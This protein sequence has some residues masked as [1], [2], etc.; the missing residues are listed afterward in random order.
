M[1]TFTISGFSDEINEKID[2]Q[3]AHIKSLGIEYFEPRGV[4]GTNIADL[5]DEQVAYLK[6]RMDK[7]GIKVSSIGSP[8][9]KIKITDNFE[10]HIAK[11]ELVEY[12][13]YVGNYY[14]TPRAYVEE[15]LSK[16]MNVILDI[17]VQGA[18]Q[19]NEKMP[20]AV[21]IFIIP[22][23]L[24]ELKRRLE[25]RGTDTARAIEARL[26]RA[27]QEY[28]EADFYDYIIINDDAD[29]AAQEFNAIITAEGCRASRRSFYLEK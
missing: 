9:G 27:R 24:D 22:P 1:K 25:G 26:I 18:R 19:V 10:E 28:K 8:I 3:F 14:G 5:T 23:S 7:E 2:I 11:E 4:D 20:D 16:G 15:Q 12:A 29:V 6:E 21:K 17:E 13:Q